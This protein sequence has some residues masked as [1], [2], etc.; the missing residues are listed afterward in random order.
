[1]RPPQHQ[2]ITALIA[3]MRATAREVDALYALRAAAEETIR[4][5]DL[6]PLERALNALRFAESVRRGS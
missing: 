3:T 5:G 1:M 4:L 2:S 6:E